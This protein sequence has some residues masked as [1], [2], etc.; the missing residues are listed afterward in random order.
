MTVDEHNE[1]SDGAQRVALLQ[2]QRRKAQPVVVGKNTVL[3]NQNQARNTA[4]DK[5]RRFNTQVQPMGNLNTPNSREGVTD[6]APASG[7]AGATREGVE[8][9][10]VP[11]LE[12]SDSEQE[13]DKETPEKISA[14]ESSMTAY[15]EQIKYGSRKILVLAP[16]GSRQ[17][18][19]DGLGNEEVGHKHRE[20][21]SSEIILDGSGAEVLKSGRSGG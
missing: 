15:L 8:N 5:K 12:E 7:V 21:T 6:P 18:S 1:L 9:P 19:T 17:L 11:N 3:W 20:E 13:Y 4:G 14:T 2:K 10:R 16:H